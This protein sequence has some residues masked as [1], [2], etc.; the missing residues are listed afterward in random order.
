MS[1]ALVT[2]LDPDAVKSLRAGEEIL[3]SGE[4]YTARDAVHA[5]LAALCEKGEAWPFEPKG[6]V[7]YYAGPAPAPP[8]RAIGSVGPTSSYRMDHYLEMTLRTGVAATMGKGD[9]ADFVKN[10]LARYG[11]VYLAA[12]G[13]AGA[14]LATRVREAEVV[15]FEDLGPE[16]I[17]RL[18]VKDFP[19]VVAI[20]ALGGSVFER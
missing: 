18:V 16:A 1:R 15:A 10:L 7:I 19:A 9:R 4:I 12:V 17:R 8:G 2:P 5:R 3:L 13:G 11:G 6:A 14:L 20:D